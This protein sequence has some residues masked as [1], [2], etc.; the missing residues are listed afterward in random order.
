MFAVP[1]SIAKSRRQE[2]GPLLEEEL[3]IRAERAARRRSAM[4]RL[5][6][7]RRSGVRGDDWLSGRADPVRAPVRGI[8]A[9]RS[10]TMGSG[11]QIPSADSGVDSLSRLVLKPSIVL[12]LPRSRRCWIQSFRIPA[13]ANATTMKNSVNPL[14]SSPSLPQLVV[15]V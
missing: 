4:R 10:S 12:T 9:R 8:S 1:R 7:A 3:I 15:C 11:L 13:A 6:A 5:A 14:K 2:L